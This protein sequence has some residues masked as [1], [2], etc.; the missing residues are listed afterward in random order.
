[1]KNIK[2]PKYI[3]CFI[4][5]NLLYSTIYA[6]QY[7]KMSFSEL[8]NTIIHT[9]KHLNSIGRANAILISE[10]IIDVS[11]KFSPKQKRYLKGLSYNLVGKIYF[12][13]KDYKEALKNYKIADLLTEGL[14]E[15]HELT[16]DINNNIALTYL[17]GFN[18]PGRALKRINNIYKNSSDL[19]QYSQHILKL[20]L[21][22]I[23]I[24]T[25]HFNK[26]NKLLKHCKIYF[27]N[28]EQYSSKL[29]TTYA[30]LV[31][32]MIVSKTTEQQ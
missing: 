20:N 3:I 16:I 30:S 21:A 18:K 11:E 31:N 26:A 7:E 28:N 19:N 5:L 22:N 13:N 8:Q 29:A 15:H 25:K 27:S 17:I 24:K 23:Y 14:K 10:T 4:C 9:E 1:M 12:S 6:N 2:T 32:I